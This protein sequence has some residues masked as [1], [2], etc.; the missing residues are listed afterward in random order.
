VLEAMAMARPV[1]ASPAAFT[2]IDA[3]PGRDLLVAEGPA[4]QAEA[5]LTLL[6]DRARADRIGMAARRRMEAVYGW[7]AQLAPLAG[8]AG[9]APA[10]AAA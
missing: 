10:Q 3:L 9:L 5:V 6:G 7:E 1:V 8:L 2:G 4:D